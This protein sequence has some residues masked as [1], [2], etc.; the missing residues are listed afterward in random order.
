M[1]EKIII[2]NTQSPGDYIVL[3]AAIRDITRAHPGRYEIMMDVPQP[4]VFQANPHVSLFQR[5]RN[6]RS[7]VAKYPLIGQSN[8]QRAHFMWGFIE[9]LNKELGTRAVLTEFR[10]DLH[11]TEHEKKNPPVNVKKPYWVFAS[12]GKRDFT[13]K[14]WDPTCWQRVVD[15]MKP[16]FNLVQVGGGSHIHPATKGVV[17]LVAKT[18][19]RELMHFIYHS[20]GV[21]CVVTCLMHIAAAFNKPCIVVAGGREPWWWEAYNVEN[22]LVNMRRGIPTWEPPVNDNFIPH[23]YLHTIGQLSCCTK[24][25]CWKSRIEGK[26]SVCSSPVTQNGRT[27]PRCLQMITPEHV[28]RAVDWYY[29]NGILTRGTRKDLILPPVS[30]EPSG[31]RML[32]LQ[33]AMDKVTAGDKWLVYAE[34]KN[35]ELSPEAKKQVIQR[36]QSSGRSVG[37]LVCWRPINGAVTAKLAR[38]S[39]YTY[40]LERLP[41]R[42]GLSRAYYFRDS[43]LVANVDTLKSMAWPP[44]GISDDIFDVALGEGLR[45]NGVRL[46]DIGDLVSFV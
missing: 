10:P 22:R 15:L 2:R 28:V 9:Y 26:S 44:A 19:F 25:G 7:V 3:S 18:S 5:A 30:K 24:G 34:G 45:Q 29:E 21:M 11:L 41:G 20:E 14:W 40:N 12:G 46:V 36:L 37:G 6:V 1:A 27:I 23:Q 33:A 43:L 35:R 4:A 42:M 16:R 39:W 17:D 32:A 38:T 31:S 13:A 8:Q